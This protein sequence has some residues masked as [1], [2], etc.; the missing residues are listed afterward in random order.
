MLPKEIVLDQVVT[1]KNFDELIEM[2]ETSHRVEHVQTTLESICLKPDGTLQTPAGELRVTR[3]FLE[4]SSA[5]IGMNLGYFYN[6]T[7]ELFCENFKQR[8]AETTSPITISRVGDVATGL[9]LDDGKARYRPAR[10]GN[11]L[12]AIGRLDGL[13]L[14]RASVSFAGVDVELVRLGNVVEP[15]IGDIVEVGVAVSNSESGGRQLKAAAYSYRLVCTN[16]AV[17][18]DEIGIARWLNDPRMTEAAS[19]LAFQKGLTLLADKLESVAALYQAAI[20]RPVPDVELWN[21]WR[22]VARHLPR[23]EADDVFGMSED[24]RRDLQQLIRLRGPREPAL[25]TER[26]AYEVHNQITHAAHGRSFRIR[27]DLQELGGEFLSRAAAWPPA[28]N[29]N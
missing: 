23:S 13:S 29:V 24:E 15:V 17:M 18:A 14:R 26:N 21:A 4:H 28:V 25:A 22:R 1:P 9:I 8:K 19:L 27:R 11:V 5:A 20:D 10:T 2:V 16:G 12:R 3:D 7:P 6:I